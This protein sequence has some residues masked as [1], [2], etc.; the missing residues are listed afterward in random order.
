MGLLVR[1]QGKCLIGELL[2]MQSDEMEKHLCIQNLR[3]LNN[4]FEWN[5]NEL[6][7]L[8][9]VLGPTQ[10]KIG[11]NDAAA[12]MLESLIISPFLFLI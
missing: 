3:Q 1:T 9:L 5:A 7:I 4:N 10:I 11:S 6:F 8:G 12:A 2:H